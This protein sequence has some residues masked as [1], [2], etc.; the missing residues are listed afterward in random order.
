[1]RGRAA[2][3]LS[4]SPAQF[5]VE[6]MNTRS[7]TS[8]LYILFIKN[9]FISLQNPGRT[10]KEMLGQKRD[11]PRNW[12]HHLAMASFKSNRTTLRP[13]FK[14]YFTHPWRRD[15]RTIATGLN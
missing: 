4:L 8:G 11:S 13:S 2:E 12:L 9:L 5:R 7:C 1:M 3:A 10:M 6:V 14:K 15:D